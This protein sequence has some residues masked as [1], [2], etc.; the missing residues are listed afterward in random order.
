MK[1]DPIRGQAIVFAFADGPMAK[2]TIEHRFDDRGRVSFKMGDKVVRAKKC[3]IASIGRDVHA[4]S[5]LGDSG[6]TLTVILDFATNELTAF[7]SNEK[8]LGVQHG[9]FEVLR[10]GEDVGAATA[11]DAHDE[12][13]GHDEHSAR[14]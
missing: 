4:I 12:T 1:R 2:K 8:E 9:T 6:Y 13:N 5:Y 14:N 7:S 10:T 3:E 11:H